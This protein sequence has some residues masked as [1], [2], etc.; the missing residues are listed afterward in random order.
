MCDS[1]LWKEKKW[2]PGA[3]WS[4]N[5]ANL[6]SLGQLGTLSEKQGRQYLGNDIQGCF[7]AHTHTRKLK[8]FETS[9]KWFLP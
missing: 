1:Q 4:A 5:L 6:A 7:L 9:L 8:S 3:P 2:I